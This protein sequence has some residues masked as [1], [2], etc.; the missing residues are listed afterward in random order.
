MKESRILEFK[1]DITNSFLKTVSAFANFGSGTILFGV[2]DYGKTVGV[3]DPDKA[4]LDVENR[5]NDSVKPKPQYLISVNR[6]TNVITLNIIEG[7]YKP[8]FYKGKAYRRSDTATVE[9]DQVELRRLTLEGE[10]LYYEGLPCGSNDLA[11]D[12]FES[13]LV[14]KLGIKTL[15]D[16][17]LRTFG[18]INGDGKYNNASALFSDNNHFYGIDIARFGDSISEI[19]DRETISGVSILKEYDD[20]VSAFRRYYQY[21]IVQGIERKT[22]DRIPEEAFRETVANALVHRTWDINSHIRIAMFSDR[23]EISSPGGLPKG[24]SKEEYLNGA[25]SNLRNPIIGN[26][27]FR[28]RYI[29]MFGTGIRRIRDSYANAPIKPDFIVTDNSIGVI[30][31]CTDKRVEVAEDGR[32]AIEVL[33]DGMILSSREISEKLGWSKDKTIRVLNKLLA[34]G[35]VQKV[36]TGRGTQYRKR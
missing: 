34:A 27:F 1:R 30:L 7:K 8:Y 28:L 26:V 5:I 33:T 21:E 2:D 15:N 19:L 36:G 32:K 16:D 3:S 22:I 24:I 31:P 25:I 18:F 17:I 9:V 20:A 13:K 10:N 12:Y 4:R 11:F 29:E 6:R 14:E 23:I 35:Y